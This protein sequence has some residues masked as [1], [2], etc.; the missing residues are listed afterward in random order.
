MDSSHEHPPIPPGEAPILW[1]RDPWALVLGIAPFLVVVLILWLLDF[2]GFLELLEWINAHVIGVSVVGLVAVLSWLALFG[3]KIAKSFDYYLRTLDYALNRTQG[4]WLRGYS[5]PMVLWTTIALFVVL[6]GPTRTWFNDGLLLG[7]GTIV[8]VT[9][10]ATWGFACLARAD[11]PLRFV[12]TAMLLTAIVAAVVWLWCRWNL[13]AG[14]DATWCFP[15]TATVEE[16]SKGLPVTQADYV[17]YPHTFLIFIGLVCLIACGSRWLASWMFGDF[18]QRHP[19]WVDKGIAGGGLL[20]SAE[21]FVRPDP[22][23]F[24]VW[25]V[26]RSAFTTPLGRPHLFLF[27]VAVAI[28]LAPHAYMNVAAVVSALAA[29]YF[30][31]LAGVHERLDEFLTLVQRNFFQGVLWGV[32]FLVIIL[33]ACRYFEVSYVA[34]LMNSASNSTLIW[35]VVALYATLWFYKYWTGYTLCEH[36]LGI[37]NPQDPTAVQIA[38]DLYPDYQETSVFPAGRALQIHGTRFAAVGAFPGKGGPFAAWQFYDRFELFEAI[39]K[40]QPGNPKDHSKTATPQA[41]DRDYGLS[42]LRQRIHFYDVILDTAVAAILLALLIVPLFSVLA[43]PLA[44]LAADP[45]DGTFDFESALF[46]REDKS[47]PVVLF[48]ASGGGTRAALYS[49]AVLRGL[50]DIGALGDVKLASGVS[51]GST[52][53]AHLSIDRDALLKPGNTD[54]WKRYAAGMTAPFIDDVLC[55]SLETRVA[56]GTRLGTLL[57]ESFHRHLESSTLAGKRKKMSEAKFGIIFNTTLAG[58]ETDPTNAGSRLIVTNV[59]VDAKTFPREQDQFEGLEKELLRYVVVDDPNVPVTTG[60][61]LSANFP[62]VFS[63]ALVALKAKDGSV[64]RHWVTD[65]GAAENRGVISLLFVLRRALKKEL[66]GKK[67]APGPIQIV[68]AEA[69]GVSLDFSQDRGIGSA[70]GASEKFA[71]QLTHELLSKIKKDYEDLGGKHLDVHFL[72]MPLVL[73]SNRG[74]IGTHWKLPAR[75]TIENPKDDPQGEKVRLILTDLQTRQLIMDLFVDQKDAGKDAH[76]K[77]LEGKQKA[78]IDTARSWIEGEGPGVDA[79]FRVHRANWQ[80]LVDT[81]A[82]LPKAKN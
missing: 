17:M 29:I 21:L 13:I 19:R 26:L 47:R 79:R 30:L 51:G 82:K 72:P 67:R 75:I 11:R 81:F 58:V 70:L 37:L 4:G 23:D 9:G 43:D 65:G 3:Q 45:G 7:L 10:L 14:V 54:A 59:K 25:A 63:N 56:Y 15:F 1:P 48:A 42:D 73:R 6:F 74:G 64:K 52:A 60:A 46:A 50:D 12:T 33:A 28:F 68:I 39:L 41:L 44:E 62:P 5:L 77:E 22:P 49:A 16:A 2:F 76:G 80:R 38:H 53:I 55:G 78:A 40:R 66:E 32:S 27:P 34:T 8:V 20:T 61:A 57:D 71:S 18:K 36:L 31:A 69:S 24:S 35:F